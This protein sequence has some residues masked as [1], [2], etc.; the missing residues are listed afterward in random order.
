MGRTAAESRR[1]AGEQMAADIVAGLGRLQGDLLA[2]WDP[3]RPS[4][5]RT[6]GDVER[7]WSE[8]VEPRLPDFKSLRRTWYDKAAPEAGSRW[9]ENW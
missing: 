5:L 3:D 8:V 1:E 7:F 6:F 2:T 9:R 4:R